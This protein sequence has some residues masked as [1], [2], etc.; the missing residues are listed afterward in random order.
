VEERKYIRF[1]AFAVGIGTLIMG[2]KFFAFRT[3]GSNAILS[4]AMESIINVVAGTFALYSLILAAKPRDKDH[5]Y[6]HG[7]IEFISSGIEGTLILIAGIAIVW[8]AVGDLIEPHELTKLDLGLYLSAGAG[9]VN[10]GLGWITEA[11][12]RKHSSPT[13][14]ASGKHLKSDGYTSLGLIIGLAIV[15]WTGLV[16]IDS[17]IALGFGLFIGFI[18]IKEMR[19]SVA[20]IMDEADFD[21][22]E[23]LITEIDKKRRENWIDLH[24]FRAQKFGKSI[25][26]DCHLTLPHYLTVEKAHAEVEQ[27][28]NVVSELHP[29]G[30]EMFI[31]TD[32]CRPSSCRICLKKECAVRESEYE[33]K[34]QWTLDAALNNSMHK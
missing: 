30:L 12:G 32:P 16:W 13:M 28:E 24:N 5:P 3:T 23:T 17:V 14:V 20:G 10:Y 29:Q 25:H 2:V 9:F 26:I 11:Y 21:L 15:L 34:I 18:G 1:Q 19:K 33:E 6:G 4:D 31:H 27:L 7:K 22:L 8:K